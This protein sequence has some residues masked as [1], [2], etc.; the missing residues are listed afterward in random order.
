VT[1]VFG[2]G[3]KASKAA[4]GFNLT[5]LSEEVGELTLAQGVLH[6]LKD[7]SFGD[8]S[9]IVSTSEEANGKWRPNG[10]SHT[11]SVEQSLVFNFHALAIEH[12]V[13]ALLSTGSVEAKSF[14]YLAGLLNHSSRPLRRSPVSSQT[15]VDQPRESTDL[16]FKRS[17]VVGSVG[18]YN[19]CI[20]ELKSLQRVAHAFDHLLA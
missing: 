9:I 15:I 3:S 14:S 19:I 6:E 10:G 8:V 18:K 17:I 20:L 5:F 2:D 13:L 16:L 4:F 7:S 12:V 11:S 1:Q